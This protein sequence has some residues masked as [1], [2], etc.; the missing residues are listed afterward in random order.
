MTL[1]YGKRLTQQHLAKAP[2]TL[3]FID[4]F[5][6]GLFAIVKAYTEFDLWNRAAPEVSNISSGS[7]A[8]W[9]RGEGY[10]CRRRGRRTLGA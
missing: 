7:R 5:K 9:C 3:T 10:W 8:G 6:A 1:E 2:T 4:R